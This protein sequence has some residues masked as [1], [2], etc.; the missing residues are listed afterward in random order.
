MF[1]DMIMIYGIGV[2]VKVGVTSVLEL[3]IVLVMLKATSAKV[4]TFFN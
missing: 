4:K 2:Q 3:A 1:V